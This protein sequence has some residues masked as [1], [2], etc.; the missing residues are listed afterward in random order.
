[1]SQIIPTTADCP[2]CGAACSARLFE[3]INGDVLPLQVDAILDGSFERTTC[4]RC[5]TVFQP[6]HHLLFAKYTARLWIVMYPFRSRGEFETLERGVAD[7]LARNFAG[8]P[9]SVADGLSAVRPRLV[10]GQYALAEAVRSARDALDPPLLECA[11]LLAFQRSL[12]QLFPLGPT[13]LVYERREPDQLVF[14]VRDLAGGERLGELAITAA[15]LGETQPLMAGFAA[16]HP[17]LFERPYVS[18]VR[19]LRGDAPPA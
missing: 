19:Y 9:A 4:S 8:A 2:G 6:E 3:S 7:V 17:E 16:S 11:K 5:G 13:E 1:M 14:G 12:P 18:V 15:L 10:F